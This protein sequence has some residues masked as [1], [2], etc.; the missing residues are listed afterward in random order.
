MYDAVHACKSL[1]PG[2]TIVDIRCRCTCS[3]HVLSRYNGHVMKLQIQ[4][5]DIIVNNYAPQQTSSLFM[6]LKTRFTTRNVIHELN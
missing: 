3:L 5:P 1:N 4:Y 2:V 6:Q